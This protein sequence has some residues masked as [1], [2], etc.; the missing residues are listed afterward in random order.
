M[1]VVEGYLDGKV[2]HDAFFSNKEDAI[3]VFNLLISNN[4]MV[5]LY[6]RFVIRDGNTI[7]FDTED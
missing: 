2:K 1:L 6:D 5:N 7:L 4:Y 3:K